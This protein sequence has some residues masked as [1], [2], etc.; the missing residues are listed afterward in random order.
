MVYIEF[1]TIKGR[2]YKYERRSVRNGN[3]VIHTSKYLGPV[4]PVNK[5]RNPNYVRRF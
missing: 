4:E 1:K 5:R 2:K 3:R